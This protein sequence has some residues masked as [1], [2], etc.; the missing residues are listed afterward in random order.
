M[1]ECLILGDS[2]AVGTARYR[3]ECA[4]YAESG[5][6][7]SQWNKAYLNKDISA[8]VVLI[9]L[10]TNDYSG[11]K[12]RVELEKMRTKL[13][14]ARVYWI[15]PAIKLDVQTIVKEIAN[16]NGDNIIFIRSLQPDQIHPTWIGYKDIAGATKLEY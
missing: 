5:L 3:P 6:N 13:G 8:K 9:S 4:I 7:S 11:V 10:G 1:F 12:T 15:M 14:S 16:A 2:I